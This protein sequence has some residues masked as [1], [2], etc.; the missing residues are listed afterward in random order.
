MNP[1]C[2]STAAFGLIVKAAARQRHDG[3]INRGSTA[4]KLAGTPEFMAPELYEE[5]YD[6]RVDVYSYG[7]CLLELA[8]MEYPYAECRNAAQ[9]Y[10]KVTLV[11][12]S[13][14][15][16]FHR[17]D[18]K[19]QLWAVLRCHFAALQALLEQQ[20]KLEATSGLTMRWC[21][22]ELMV[23]GCPQCL[24]GVRPAGL[25]NV[26]SRE[27]AEFIAICIRTKDERPRSRQL[28]KHPYFD[29]IRE[30]AAARAEALSATASQVIVH[31][32]LF[33]LGVSNSEVETQR[34]RAIVVAVVPV[35]L[36]LLRAPPAC[37]YPDHMQPISDRRLLSL[38]FVTR[39]F[40]FT[41]GHL[42]GL[43]ERV[44]LRQRL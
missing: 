15:C 26:P 19:R 27:L 8:T 9:I 20:L 40:W 28:L 44:V 1:W 17:S 30:R 35:A 36:A 33:A 10:R 38:A 29:S 16:L 11:S 31:H 4:A 39:I 3:G 34:S 42:L 37:A 6:D 23:R 7:M 14:I 5:E 13:H 2:M 12:A 24:Q 18:F 41:G 22:P 43:R 32:A 25:A 21:S